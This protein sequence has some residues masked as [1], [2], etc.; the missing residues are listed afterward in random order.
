M[1]EDMLFMIYGV[2][3]PSSKDL[4]TST[5]A[6]HFAYLE[7]HQDVLVL[8]GATLGEDGETRTG[9]VLIINVEDIAAANRFSRNEPFRK[10]GVFEQVT[11]TRM[12]HGQWNPG[13][14]PNL[15][16]GH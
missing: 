16:E 11:V 4:R 3:G 7:E 1:A 10:A 6:E 12:R 13:A 15:P 8:G 5:K 2:D 14:A 9:S